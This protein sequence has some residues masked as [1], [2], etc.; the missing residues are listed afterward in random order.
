[1]RVYRQRNA[2]LGHDTPDTQTRDQR[3]GTDLKDLCRA[4][5][6]FPQQEP[7]QLW[8][9]PKGNRPGRWANVSVAG[10]AVT[11]WSPQ[12][13]RTGHALRC[14]AVRVWEANPP[15]GC[16]A[17]E[18]ILLTSEPVRNLTDAL[19]IAG[20]YALRWL[21][22]EYHNC[23]KSGCQ[24]EARQLETAAR[25]EPLIAMLCAV[26]VRLLQ[27]KND[28]R[29]TPDRP[30]SACVPVE[31]VQTLSAL[32]EV[33]SK[34]KS[35]AKSNAKL[36]AKSP[37]PPAELTVR[38]FIHAVAKLGGFLGRKGDGEPGWRT[39]WRGW[40]ELTLIHA[41]YELAR[42]EGKRYG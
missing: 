10:G 4:M 2:S 13:D 18:W 14:W 21:V 23:L 15:A 40:L 32:I 17:V 12:L 20:Y 29:L 22:E 8:V 37:P 6:A 5:P 9:G 39:L 7:R 38:Q 11:I 1:V 35:N 19:R 3:R 41:G 31:L 36:K 25:L 28:A 34:A 26:A 30:A 27:L 42:K 24:V 33:D 16:E